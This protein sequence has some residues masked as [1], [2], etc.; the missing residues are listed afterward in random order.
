[1]EE[2]G[3]HNHG[4]GKGLGTPGPSPIMPHVYLSGICQLPVKRGGRKCP[5]VGA[6]AVVGVL[7]C[8]IERG[9]LLCKL[10]KVDGMS[11]FIKA[12]G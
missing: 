5:V 12:R 11:S 7:T 2:C 4:Y 1:M 10:I 8:L 9:P 6:G 3:T